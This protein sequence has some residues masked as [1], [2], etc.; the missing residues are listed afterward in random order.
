MKSYLLFFILAAATVASPGPGVIL[1]LSNALRTGFSNT[2]AGILGVACGA[3]VVAGISATSVGMILSTSALAFTA[4]KYVGSAYL[5]YLGIKLFRAKPVQMELPTDG[6]APKGHAKTSNGMRH[7]ASGIY[8]QLTNP[9]A[10]F[11]FMSIFPQF[12]DSRKN[13]FPQFTTLVFIYSGLVTIIHTF[14]ALV[15]QKASN[16][17]TTPAGGNIMRKTSS[18]AFIFFGI[19]IARS[20]R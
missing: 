6:T 19:M 18:A 10:V 8:L 14:Y 17:I 20:T 12:I 3:M 7:F 13:Y 4:V 15:A 16:W 1:T 11:F 9:K 2:F 5:I